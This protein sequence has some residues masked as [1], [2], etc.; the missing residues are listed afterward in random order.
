MFGRNDDSEEARFVTEQ[1]K[2]DGAIP[3]HVI[4]DKETGVQYLYAWGGAGG[5]LTPLLDENGQIT[6]KR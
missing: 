1:M 3:C 5:G 4:T 6:V 2:T